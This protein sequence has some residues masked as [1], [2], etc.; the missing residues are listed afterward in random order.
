MP[1]AALIEQPM[2]NSILNPQVQT[3]QQYTRVHRY[4]KQ[5]KAN[6]IKNLKVYETRG[7]DY[8]EKNYR[9]D[10]S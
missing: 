1:I 3:R 9:K 5:D 4:L 7:N 10:S 2:E 8:F 6:K